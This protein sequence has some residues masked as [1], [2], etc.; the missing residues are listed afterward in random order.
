MRL[1]IGD[2]VEVYGVPGVVG[3]ITGVHPSEDGRAWYDVQVTYHRV[4]E[5]LVRLDP[6]TT[7]VIDERNRE[8]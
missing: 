6:A 2:K 1:S 3:V 5:G 8:V 4:S 7:L